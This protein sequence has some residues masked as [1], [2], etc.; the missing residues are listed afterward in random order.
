LI[1][2]GEGSEG[3][4]AAL[5]GFESAAALAAGVDGAVADAGAADAAG[6][7]DDVEAGGVDVGAEEFGAGAWAMQGAAATIKSAARKVVR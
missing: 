7:A 4:V 6:A 5:T 3:S 2:S 1:T